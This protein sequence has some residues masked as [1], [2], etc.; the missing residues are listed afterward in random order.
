M[1]D[2]TTGRSPCVT[3]L[4]NLVSLSPKRFSGR[5]PHPVLTA[6]CHI[7][8]EHLC[9]ELACDWGGVGGTGARG[10]VDA[11]EFCMPHHRQQVA[12]LAC[13][14]HHVYAQTSPNHQHHHR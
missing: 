7:S 10:R 4:L 8:T 9:C 3:H 12:Q 5:L 14:L 13:C 1:N 11:V 6:C 2:T